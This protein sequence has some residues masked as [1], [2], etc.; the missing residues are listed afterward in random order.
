M[1]PCYSYHVL[2]TQL[3]WG[4]RPAQCFHFTSLQAASHC[5]GKFLYHV[6]ELKI[7]TSSP[8]TYAPQRQKL[9]LGSLTDPKPVH[10]GKH[11]CDFSSK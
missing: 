10:I 4:G 9:T 7:V 1:K 8:C 11:H 5:E 3:L 6:E 2:A